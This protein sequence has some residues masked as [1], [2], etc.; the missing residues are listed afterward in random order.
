MTVSYD[1]VQNYLKASLTVSNSVCA[2]LCCRLTSLCLR[3]LHSH[4]R[5]LPRCSF[6]SPPLVKG[7]NREGREE[8][9]GW[10]EQEAGVQTAGKKITWLSIQMGEAMADFDFKLNT[11]ILNLTTVKGDDFTVLKT[12][13]IFAVEQPDDQLLITNKM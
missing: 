13:I 1:E 12:T 11:D 10:V 2:A 9:W 5:I 7:D 6:P 8:A 3:R 4:T